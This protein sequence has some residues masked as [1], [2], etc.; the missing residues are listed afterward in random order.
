MYYI[1]VAGLIYYIYPNM[2]KHKKV[3]EDE[4]NYLVRRR[5]I[6]KD[7]QRNLRLKTH[8]PKKLV[9]VFHSLQ[10]TKADEKSLERFA[11]SVGSTTKAF[12]CGLA[13]ES[14]LFFGCDIL[15]NKREFNQL[16]NSPLGHEWMG[17]W[18]MQLIH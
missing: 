5:K 3:Q 17:K 6:M 10:E 4:N 1:Y 14:L 13:R 7:K 15:K 11:E 18:I 8:T 16:Q 9:E 12:L 2:A